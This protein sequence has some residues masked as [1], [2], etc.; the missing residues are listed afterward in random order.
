MITK[1]FVLDLSL[2]QLQSI[3]DVSAFS[4]I[5]VLSDAVNYT[6]TGTHFLVLHKVSFQLIFSSVGNV[7]SPV[8]VFF[9][10]IPNKNGPKSYF[11]IFKNFR[12][13]NFIKFVITSTFHSNKVFTEISEIIIFKRVSSFKKFGKHSTFRVFTSILIRARMSISN[14]LRSRFVICS[15]NAFLPLFSRL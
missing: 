15:S 12:N 11:S 6:E 14:L 9:L 10:C 5:L 7:Y 3:T 2:S 4:F 8:E 1:I 13:R